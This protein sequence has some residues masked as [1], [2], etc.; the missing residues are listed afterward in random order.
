MY[1]YIKALLPD[2]FNMITVKT[3]PHYHNTSRTLLIK[4]RSV[5]QKQSKYNSIYWSKL[6]ECHCHEEQ[7]RKFNIF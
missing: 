2:I 1:K 4:Y 7:F 5:I 6:L 3:F